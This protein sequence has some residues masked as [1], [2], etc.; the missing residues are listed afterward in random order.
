MDLVSRYYKEI[1]M[2]FSAKETI[3]IKF[4]MQSVKNELAFLSKYYLWKPLNVQVETEQ[5]LQ[6]IRYFKLHNKR[7]QI[8]E[9]IIHP[10][11][12][13]LLKDYEESLDFHRISI[14]S[15]D[16]SIVDMQAV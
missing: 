3:Y 16:K 12:L 11:L 4:G 8:E 7:I 6:L 1:T 10:R 5:D 15:I 14:M 2:S 9:L 13:K